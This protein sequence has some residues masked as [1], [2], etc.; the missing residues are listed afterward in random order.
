ME[1]YVPGSLE[2]S[3]D[4]GAECEY[5]DEDKEREISVV[6]SELLGVIDALRN[7][8][9]ADTFKNIKTS[10]TVGEYV[11]DTVDSLKGAESEQQGY[12]ADGVR[13]VNTGALSFA[14]D[15]LSVYTEFHRDLIGAI[16]KCAKAMTAGT[17]VATVK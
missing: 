2:T 17:A 3:A 14:A 7:I 13:T 12:I 8:A 6:K 16:S 4:Y 9:N 1:E 11:K 15:I 5:V 10:R